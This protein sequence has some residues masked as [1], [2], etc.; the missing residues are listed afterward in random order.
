MVSKSISFSISYSRVG[1]ENQS[2]VT[3]VKFTYFKINK[4]FGKTAVDSILKSSF[5]YLNQKQHGIHICWTIVS[6]RYK[7]QTST[8][9]NLFTYENCKDED[10]H[11]PKSSH[12][13]HFSRNLSILKPNETVRETNQNKNYKCFSLLIIA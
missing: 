10:P 13:D 4:N 5:I 1:L 7:F 6:I 11:Q 9:S 2:S 8:L 3:V 12:E